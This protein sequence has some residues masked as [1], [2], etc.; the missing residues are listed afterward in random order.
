MVQPGPLLNCPCSSAVEHSLG[1]GEVSGS[2]PDEGMTKS[3]ATK[4][5][6]RNKVRLTY[7]QIY[8]DMSTI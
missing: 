6:I 2:S 4:E 8:L 3:I 7:N 5:S 1:K